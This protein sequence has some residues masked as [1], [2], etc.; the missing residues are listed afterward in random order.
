MIIFLAGLVSVNSTTV[1]KMCALGLKGSFHMILNILLFHA[2][3]LFQANMP[4]HMQ[5]RRRVCCICWNR[6]GK[7]VDT[8]IEPG[9][10]LEGGSTPTTKQRTC[11]IVFQMFCCT[12]FSSIFLEWDGLR[13]TNISTYIVLFLPITWQTTFARSDHRGH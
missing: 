4:D 6:C 3:N 13:G 2:R 7:K 8:I 9:S 12:L 11:N 1:V 10:K 5:C